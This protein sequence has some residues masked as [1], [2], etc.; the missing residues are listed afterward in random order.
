[1]EF[2]L[3]LVPLIFFD[4]TDLETLDLTK[5]SEK[6]E[7]DEIVT[8]QTIEYNKDTKQETWKQVLVLGISQDYSTFYVEYMDND[9]R[10][11]VS[12]LNLILEGENKSLFFER[13]QKA[14]DYRES[15]M[16]YERFYLFMDNYLNPNE[17][18]LKPKDF[19]LLLSKIDKKYLRN[20]FVLSKVYREVCMLDVITIY[21]SDYKNKITKDKKLMLEYEKRNFPKISDFPVTFVS[22]PKIFDVKIDIK[23]EM[24]LIRSV[25]DIIKVKQKARSFITE[26]FIEFDDKISDVIEFCKKIRESVK[27]N[28]NQI[29]ISR[30]SE[31]L[32]MIKKLKNFDMNLA[33]TVDKIIVRT[34]SEVTNN[35][36]N[37]FNDFLNEKVTPFKKVFTD[38]SEMNLKSE[39]TELN[40][41]I[42]YIVN[43]W[44]EANVYTIGSLFLKDNL[45]FK[46]QKEIVEK[47]LE[48]IRLFFEKFIDKPIDF[49][50]EKVTEFDEKYRYAFYYEF[51]DTNRIIDTIDIDQIICFHQLSFDCLPPTNYLTEKMIKNFIYIKNE[52]KDLINELIR[53]KTVYYMPLLVIDF[54]YLA[55][56]SLHN[57]EYILKNIDFFL[58]RH[59]LSAIESQY[60]LLEFT[61]NLLKV[62]PVDLSSFIVLKNDMDKAFLILEQINNEVSNIEKI[63]EELQKSFSPFSFK[64]SRF[65]F[66]FGFMLSKFT[67]TLPLRQ[68]EL[69]ERRILI[70]TEYDEKENNLLIEYNEL[71]S[72]LSLLLRQNFTKE[73]EKVAKTAEELFSKYESACNKYAEIKRGD[74]YLERQTFDETKLF[75]GRRLSNCLMKLWVSTKEYSM[76]NEKIA[77]TQIGLIDTEEI[78]K[79]FEK[80]VGSINDACDG[81]KEFQIPRNIAILVESNVK[82][83]KS[84]IPIIN[85]L[86]SIYLRNRHWTMINDLFKLDHPLDQ[87]ATLYYLID[88]IVLN[89]EKEIMDIVK[90]AE[91]EYI[92]E[93]FLDGIIASFYD[94]TFSI[95]LF[96]CSN[97]IK[98]GISRLQD[99]MRD[100][101]K[102]KKSNFKNLFLQKIEKH[103]NFVTQMQDFVTLLRKI[104]NLYLYQNDFMEAEDTISHQYSFYLTFGDIKSNLTDLLSKCTCC[105]LSISMTEKL[106]VIY[107]KIRELKEK[108]YPYLQN[109]RKEYYRLQYLANS[110][111]FNYISSTKNPERFSEQVKSLFPSL[112]GMIIENNKIIGVI[113][114]NSEQLRLNPIEYDIKDVPLLLKTIEMKI[115]EKLTKTVIDI[116]D[117]SEKYFLDRVPALTYQEMFVILN[118]KFTKFVKNITSE[119]E[120]SIAVDRINNLKKSI[121]FSCANQITINSLDSLFDYFELLLN[122]IA[123]LNSWNFK[124]NERAASRKKITMSTF[125][126]TNL[127]KPVASQSSLSSI[128]SRPPSDMSEEANKVM[129]SPTTNWS[130]IIEAFNNPSERKSND[131]LLPENS[132]TKS[133]EILTQSQLNVQPKLNKTMEVKQ[134]PRGVASQK[135][136]IT[137]QHLTRKKES[138]SQRLGIPAVSSSLSILSNS[139]NQMSD[140]ES[141]DS[142]LSSFKNFSIKP[143]NS[144]FFRPGE[145]KFLNL[146]YFTSSIDLP[147]FAQFVL[148]ENKVFVKFKNYKINYG[149]E[150]IPNT[151]K[152]DDMPTFDELL[153]FVEA[154]SYNN[155]CCIIHDSLV[156]NKFVNFVAKFLGKFVFSV[157]SSSEYFSESID[158]LLNS[159]DMEKV[160]IHLEDFDFLE[161]SIQLS[162]SYKLKNFNGLLITSGF[163]I[164]QVLYTFMR[165]VIIDEELFEWQ[166][167]VII[168]SN[169]E[170]NKKQILNYFNKNDTNLV[171]IN[172]RSEIEK[173]SLTEEDIL[174]I[175]HVP[176]MSDSSIYEF[177]FP[178]LEIEN[179]SR[180]KIPSNTKVVFESSSVDKVPELLRDYCNFI[181]YR[182]INSDFWDLYN[183]FPQEIVNFFIGQT[184]IYSNLQ[185]LSFTKYL[186]A[187]LTSYKPEEKQRIINALKIDFEKLELNNVVNCFLQSKESV[188]IYGSTKIKMQIWL[189]SFLFKY[190]DDYT[191]VFDEEQAT[192]SNVC[193]IFNDVDFKK[194]QKHQQYLILYPDYKDFAFELSYRYVFCPGQ[195]IKSNERQELQNYDDFK[196]KIKE[197]MSSISL[198]SN[199]QQNP[200]EI[201]NSFVLENE[202][203]IDSLQKGFDEKKNVIILNHPN[204]KIPNLLSIKYPKEGDD[205]LSQKQ[206]FQ[207]LT[208]FRYV[209]VT[210]FNIP[211][212]EFYSK[213]LFNEAQFVYDE[214]EKNLDDFVIDKFSFATELAS[215]IYSVK[216][217]ISAVD[218]IKKY[219]FDLYN[220]FN[221][222]LEKEISKI[223]NFIK[224]LMKLIDYETKCQNEID[225][226]KADIEH[227]ETQISHFDEL[228]KESEE[229]L[230]QKR[231]ISKI[232][233]NKLDKNYDY[234]K[235]EYDDIKRKQDVIV[236]KIQESVDFITNLDNNSLQMFKAI[237]SPTPSILP[238]FQ[239]F[240]V[241]YDVNPI[242]TEV[243]RN[244][245]FDYFTPMQKVIQSANFSNSMPNFGLNFINRTK[246]YK[247]KKILTDGGGLLD[248]ASK[249]N[250]DFSNIVNWFHMILVFNEESESLKPLSE[251]ERIFGQKIKEIEIIFENLE[252]QI[253]LAQSKH[254]DLVNLKQK[255]I[256]RKENQIKNLEIKLQSFKKVQK[257]NKRVKTE[258]EKLNEKNNEL[259][260]DKERSIETSFIISLI[261][262]VLSAMNGQRHLQYHN[263][264]QRN[265]AKIEISENLFGK[266]FYSKIKDFGILNDEILTEKVISLLNPIKNPLIY[267]PNGFG[268]YLVRYLFPESQIL[269]SRFDKFDESSPVILISNDPTDILYFIDSK[270][271]RFIF[272]SLEIEQMPDN[273]QNATI[274]INFS[275]LN[276]MSIF[277]KLLINEKTKIDQQYMVSLQE[278]RN[279]EVKSLEMVYTNIG[280]T[281]DENSF[282]MERW[283]SLR[284]HFKDK[285]NKIEEIDQK[286]TSLTEKLTKIEN[287]EKENSTLIMKMYNDFIPWLNYSN[288]SPVFPIF[289]S[290]LKQKI[291]KKFDINEIQHEFIKLMSLSMG[292]S[293]VAFEDNYDIKF[294]DKIKFNFK[295]FNLSEFI[296]GHSNDIPLLLECNPRDDPTNLLLNINNSKV[297]N[298]FDEKYDKN[299]LRNRGLVIVRYPEFCE[300]SLNKISSF[301][302]RILTNHS[303]PSEFRL[304]IL[305]SLS[306]NSL[307]CSLNTLC[308]NA[309]WPPPCPPSVIYG[310]SSLISLA[311]PLLMTF[312]VVS[313]CRYLPDIFDDEQFGKEDVDKLW[314]QNV[315][316]KLSMKRLLDLEGF[317]GK[318]LIISPKYFEGSSEVNTIYGVNCLYDEVSGT[319]VLQKSIFPRYIKKL[320]VAVTDPN[321]PNLNCQLLNSTD[322]SCV[323]VAV[324]GYS[325]LVFIYE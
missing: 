92:L 155:C 180:I 276:L 78:S 42:E 134:T 304:V 82:E 118:L 59:C 219:A 62:E 317:E 248:R 184:Y 228:I 238:L 294:S 223:E 58:F 19:K 220:Y 119:K 14:K 18:Y 113:G 150:F 126:E 313:F 52:I 27:N 133:Q 90:I 29:F 40:L 195:L 12:R 280:N 300:S 69:K 45:I 187:S 269:S 34:I 197:N 6:L 127:L 261:S 105:V 97:F 13:R 41:T 44:E 176:S 81:L 157:H 312:R 66:N 36:I 242:V 189:Y 273:I 152:M 122:Q 307:P 83:F 153:G 260:S 250:K 277:N 120:F 145:D 8:G 215:K 165:P 160:W 240:C 135:S 218:R 20:Y 158:N 292:K 162:I 253:L 138:T 2:G 70:K 246:L 208:E 224:N 21:M 63:I 291:D 163:F 51:Y 169:Y 251:K 226:S 299:I 285:R 305:T 115:E 200:I 80:W 129:E 168:G 31:V 229:E 281:F 170:E 24:E 22:F 306:Q 93:D 177:E 166:F 61:R 259:K 204:T 106:E 15:F 64:A 87:S 25:G 67:K 125:V 156:S 103:E 188:I 50:N 26:K 283:K 53:T 74:S 252:K 136:M 174:W 296:F 279:E 234:L 324:E 128:L 227:L 43:C 71:D 257:L 7:K 114:K 212:F 185:T 95:T 10:K 96:N 77:G 264:I 309:I 47:S 191:F 298:P 303:F 302:S 171:E 132:L 205:K 130:Q 1:M 308:F 84:Y 151:F 239:A 321:D 4:D 39:M 3:E 193:V 322:R 116:A 192:E 263:F 231:E 143:Q 275:N 209:F 198:I 54:T 221:P 232:E 244:K 316:D 214:K 117:K 99:Q 222:I 76:E 290:I 9:I 247:I 144:A 268:F 72:Q 91:N 139:L 148:D 254:D 172:N 225:E 288:Y 245:N 55:R 16:R 181:T 314:L 206:Y 102:V 201:E 37:E 207:R 86:S 147:D 23:K 60:S 121:S 186:S 46:P 271:K 182:S 323:D 183:I 35:M 325:D 73:I 295:D 79:K 33:K 48:K 274:F 5:I 293:I 131:D 301:V 56:E 217:Y 108:I 94:W 30:V 194:L 190:C 49:I 175:H 111:L 85:A 284:D 161:N 199:Q 196:Q 255:T 167:N 278:K 178:Y 109:R 65:L 216:T 140:N 149:F 241:L 233:H 110:E 173:K 311:S 265:F 267:D 318:N 179:C 32:Q 237:R 289:F 100:L 28:V 319:F 235:E 256:E 11:F 282:V 297:L 286:L 202:N 236:P 38:E 104:Y 243:G 107:D 270:K 249:V 146:P 101:R 310:K 230:Y 203:D 98:E 112:D 315:S 258:L 272:T 141:D 262:I 17:S 57:L 154:A 159:L 210:Y 89:K 137:F 75:E 142:S 287:E 124:L 213:T 68:S 266:H 320:F 88:I 123:Q 211:T 164:S